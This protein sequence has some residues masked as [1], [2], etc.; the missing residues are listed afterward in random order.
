M[1][2]K[3]VTGHAHFVENRFNWQKVSDESNLYNAPVEK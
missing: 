3:N 2:Q 1:Q